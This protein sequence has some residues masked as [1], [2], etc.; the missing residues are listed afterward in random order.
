MKSLSYLQISTYSYKFPDYIE[1]LCFLNVWIY[2]VS[3]ACLAQDLNCVSYKVFLIKGTRCKPLR[4]EV[5]IINL[6]SDIN[7]QQ[8]YI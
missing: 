8:V 3:V 7:L 6:N 2:L 1:P 5:Y 4:V